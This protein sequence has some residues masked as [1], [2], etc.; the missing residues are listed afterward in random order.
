MSY[1]KIASGLIL[2]VSRNFVIHCDEWVASLFI[3]SEGD[4][5]M[6]DYL[7][8]SLSKNMELCSYIRYATTQEIETLLDLIRIYA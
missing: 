2:C 3:P 4:V 7:E 6:I 1:H 8:K 5:A